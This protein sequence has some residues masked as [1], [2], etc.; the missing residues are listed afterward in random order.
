MNH[1]ITN[2]ERVSGT[3]SAE[4]LSKIIHEIQTVGFAV[5]ENLVSVETCELLAASIREDVE[6]VRASGKLTPHEKATGQ[7]HL[8][9]GLRRYAPY[10]R[11]DLIANPL[12]E[13]IVAS[14]IGRGAWLGFYNGNVNC[15]GSTFQPL[16]FD[17][18]FSWKTP[19][20]A[21]RDG[22]SWPPPP[23]TLGCSVALEEITLD[24]GATEIYPGTHHE[25][26]VTT[27]PA[28]DRIEKHPALMEKWTPG[29]M[30]IPAGGACIR[31]PRMWHRGVPNNSDK[32]R[33]MIAVTYHSARGQHRSGRLLSNMD[34][35]DIARCKEDQSLRVLDN[36]ELGDGRLVFQED[37]REVFESLRNLHG[38]NRNVRFVDD[39]LTVNHL[40]DAHLVGGARVV[41][42][43]G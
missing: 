4:K 27:W 19:E 28:G 23:T 2:Q 24:N 41:S 43:Q 38:I 40:L 8:Q 31:D 35:A 39:P 13:C 37:T 32:A 20:D 10:V 17:R 18:P 34:P 3:V 11:A 1:R 42:A 5:V 16:H 30:S 21:A 14:V 6:V 15:P 9:L 25:T 22:Q 33:A 12:I 36:G 7:G 29:R 26:E